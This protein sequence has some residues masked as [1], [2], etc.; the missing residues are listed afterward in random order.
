MD[1]S[2]VITFITTSATSI[3]TVAYYLYKG[4][5]HFTNLASVAE[6]HDPAD[7][8]PPVS[9][10]KKPTSLRH[11]RTTIHYFWRLTL[12]RSLDQISPWQS[13]T[14]AQSILSEPPCGPLFEHAKTSRSEGGGVIREVPDRGVSVTTIQ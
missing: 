13:G 9:T 5:L 6:L 10:D 12:Y 2:T 3:L 4:G 1:N 7:S 8:S 14:Y 11:L